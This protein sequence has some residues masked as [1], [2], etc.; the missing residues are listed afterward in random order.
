MKFQKRAFTL[1][2]LLVVVAIIAV[3]IAIL[4][5]SL[6]KARE[7]AKQTSCAA[8]LHSLWGGINNYVAEFD[9]NILPSRTQSGSTQS[10]IWSGIDVLGPELG[11][12]RGVQNNGTYQTAQYE[13]LLNMLHCPSQ[14]KY[15]DPLAVAAGTI[16]GYVSD[17]TYNENLGDGGN[18]LTTTPFVLNFPFRKLANLRPDILVITEL[19]P[20]AERGKNDWSFDNVQRLLTLQSPADATNHGTTPMAGTPH[21][22]G[23]KANML[24]ADG[25]IIADKPSIMSVPP[26]P[27][28]PPYAAN[29]ALTKTLDYLLKPDTADGTNGPNPYNHQ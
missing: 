25:S 6:G 19:H 21:A 27:T 22:N 11:M 28:S 8:N 13:K 9:G 7:R 17:Y 10:W 4:L 1:I 5:P 29:G 16:G 15:D 18:V 3:L 12:G 26:A 14:P 24:W 20:P 23:T 2:E